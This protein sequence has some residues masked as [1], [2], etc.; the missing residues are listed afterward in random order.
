M[1]SQQ[2]DI[3]D[4]ELAGPISDP[5][6][7][8]A[9]EEAMIDALC[10]HLSLYQAEIAVS[11]VDQLRARMA[12]LD[13]TSDAAEAIEKAMIPT[14]AMI[15]SETHRPERV[16]PSLAALAGAYLGPGYTARDLSDVGEAMRAAVREHLGALFCPVADALWQS[17]TATLAERLIA[18]KSNAQFGPG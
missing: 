2:V 8:W 4:S 7:P 10:E 12:H 15:G 17:T 5:S 3:P 6:A 1:F 9:K 16:V 18:R 14:I 11:F 13:L